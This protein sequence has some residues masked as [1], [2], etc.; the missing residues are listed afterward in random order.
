MNIKKSWYFAPA[1]VLCA[2][3]AP[4]AAVDHYIEEFVVTASPHNKRAG[5]V[6]GAV[7]ILDRRQLQR[8]VAA[9]LG[10]T[11]HNQPGI[12]S[13]SFGPGVGAPIIRGLG[14]KRVEILHNGTGVAD[15]SAVSPDHAIATEPLLADR[16]EVLRG[17][18]TLRYGPGAIGGVVNVIDNSIHTEEVGDFHG[19]GEMRHNTNNHENALVGRLDGGN[20]PLTYHLSGVLRDS[21][22]V[23]I[24]G[25]AA[26]DKGGSARGDIA[27]SDSETDT[28]TL[29][30]SRVTDNLVIGASVGRLDSQYGIPPGGHHHS[31][32]GHDGHHDHD[33]DTVFTR[34]DLE[35]TTYQG[36]VLLRNLPGVIEQVNIDLNHSRYQH[37]ELESPRGVRQAGTLFAIDSSEARSEITHKPLPGLTGTLGL[38]YKHRDFDA[39]GVEAFVPPST[40]RELGV[41][42]V[43]DIAVGDG[44]LELGL[45]HDRQRVRSSATGDID[46]DSFN[47]SASLLY[48]LLDSQRLGLILSRTERAP[49]AEELLANGDHVATHSYEV[50]DADL[51][52]ESAWNIELSWSLESGRLDIETSL[53][54]RRFSD[55]IHAEDNGSRFSHDRE[56]AGF[57]DADACSARIADFGSGDGEFGAAPE[58]LFYKQRDARF[59]GIEVAMTMALTDNHS[60]RLWADQVRA[61]FARGGDIPRIPPARV[62]IHWDYSQGPWST[63]LSIAHALAQDRPGT[64]Q[65]ATAS[66]TRTDFFVRYGR[67]GWALFAKGLNLSDE[68]IRNATSFLRDLAPEPGRSVVVGASYE[69]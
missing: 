43:E 19:A 46:H 15:A 67:G 39:A 49:V 22:D 3:T 26:R 27:N 7:A 4:L 59:T 63:G 40:T 45:R 42:L 18:A 56:D 12:S 64:H 1:I 53:Y 58:C 48:P 41:Y 65:A 47:A 54:H 57:S 68:E 69:F 55:F 66:Y 14:G 52:T 38:H 31:G 32:P 24:P 62:G 11:L 10:E 13:G 35:Q 2:Q 23:A 34:I 44:Q 36:K 60:L 5:D 30:T 6:P 25:Y 28:W 61:R 29:G 20:G 16:I 51:D 50:G 9:T 8:E 33:E 17:P 21:A 37:K